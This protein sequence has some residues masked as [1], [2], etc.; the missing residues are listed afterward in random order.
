MRIAVAGATGKV[1]RHVAEVLAA[2]G[3]EVVPV[4][5]GNGVDVA[6]GEGL[7]AALA[8]VE[9]VVDAANGPPEQRAATEFF[10]AA[11]RNLQAAGAR[12]GVRRIVAV[13]IIG[14]DRFG[15]GYM[16]AKVAHERALRQ[17]A[18]PVR[19][20][21]AA[22]FHELVAQ[23][24]D[25]GRKGAVSYLPRLRTHLVAAR[26]VAVEVARLATAP[27]GARPPAGVPFVEV[28]GPREEEL[29]DAARLLVA[30]R[31]E[32]LRIEAVGNPADPDAALY[33]S[34]G[35]LPGPDALRAG[36]TFDEW[37]AAA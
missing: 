28:A 19:V 11:A 9:C 23:F 2:G 30:R 10:A 5:R 6:T 26:T 1:G 29:A 3:H 18:V 7:A 21:R 16:A 34:G 32:A 15:G 33:A 27:D 25:R 12:A 4:T 8:G 37:L 35:F 17:G 22:Q 20:V 14:I 31:R 13:S 24:V 36:P